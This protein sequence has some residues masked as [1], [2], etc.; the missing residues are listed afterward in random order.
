LSLII[1]KIFEGRHSC[2]CQAT[3]HKL[4]A[5]C[6]TCGRIVCEQEGTGP[7]FFC[8]NIVCTKE[9]MAKINSGSR[10]GEKLKNDLLSKSWQGFD[11]IVNKLNKMTITTH[12]SA[13]LQKAIEHKNK[14]IEY[15]RNW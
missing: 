9:E 12:D 3:K 14:L 4:I 5:N 10:K 15:D 6:L 8:G 1:S 7:C 11:A 13:D 2:E